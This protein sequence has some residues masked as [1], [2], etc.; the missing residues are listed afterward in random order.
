MEATAG[1][2][3]RLAAGEQHSD[4]PAAQDERL[5]RPRAV[6]ATGV[7]SGLVAGALMAGALMLIAEIANEPTAVAGVDSSTWTPLTGIAAFVFGTDAFSGSF[8]PLPILAGLVLHLAVAAGYGVL[9]VA[10]IVV[11][12][13]PR[14]GAAGA[15]VQGIVYAL[16]IQIFFLALAVDAI[17]E[18]ATVYDSLPRW[19]WWAAHS[20]YGGALGLAA[21]RLLRSPT[22]GAVLHRSD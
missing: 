13:G 2:G 18:T 10:F 17:Q 9:G 15:M 11:T 16:F 21:A 1:S 14:P 5:V 8:A 20:G 19:G 7:R 12:Q 22:R 6:A 4:H 3:A